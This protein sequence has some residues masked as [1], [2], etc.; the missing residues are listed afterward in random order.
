MKMFKLKYPIYIISAMFVAVLASCSDRDLDELQ[1]ATQYDTT[2]EVFTDAFSSGEDLNAW[3]KVTN[4]NVD[5]TTVYDGSASIRID[6][7]NVTDAAGTWAGGN[8]YTSIPRDLS[9]YD[10][11][12]FYAKSTVATTMI[13]GFG[14]SSDYLVSDSIGLT[15]TWTKYYIPIPD[16]SKLTAMTSMFY[17]SAAPVDDAGYSIYI[18]D[19]KYEK[20]GTFGHPTINNTLESSMFLG[21]TTTGNI[22][23]SVSLPT[24]DVQKITAAPAYFTFASSDTSVATVSND[25]ISVVGAGTATI[26]A[27][28]F[29]GGL[30]VT[31]TGIG[32][33]PTPTY[34]S[35]SVLSIFS[36]SYTSATIY[37][38]WCGTTAI[39]KIT[40]GSNAMYYFTSFD[41]TCM[42]LF[43]SSGG[44]Q[45]ASGY[46]YLHMDVMTPNSVTSASKLGINFGDYST[47]SGVSTAI[48]TYTMS[49][50][51]KLNWIQLDI[52]VS[53]YTRSKL[54]YI[55]YV[56]T[57]LTN[58]YVDNVYFHN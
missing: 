46:S 7:P 23:L 8:I 50:S 37:D 24:G 47:G 43:D 49:S 22:S 11:L 10:C 25:T 38:F 1:K 28:G 9:G 20:L 57:N 45:D 42:V 18:D 41:W 21:E 39:S 34:S 36:D 40:I 33:A 51:S 53:S 52:P 17:Y 29:E 15:T 35:S 58:L 32:S 13:A 27:D 44:Y 4:F 16:A 14:I 26:T 55:T 56:G 48:Y 31:S 19:V 2:A 5:Y 30:V 12:T 3:G 54:G 6:V